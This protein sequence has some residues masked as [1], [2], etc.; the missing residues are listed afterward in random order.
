MSAPDNAQIDAV[1][2]HRL[3]GLLDIPD[4]RRDHFAWELRNSVRC[5]RCYAAKPQTKVDHRRRGRPTLD[6]QETDRFASFLRDL[7]QMACDLG[8]G[9]RGVFNRKKRR[10]KLVDLLNALRPIMPP[11]V[12][13]ETIDD[14]R[15]ALIER[16]VTEARRGQPCSAWRADIIAVHMSGEIWRAMGEQEPTCPDCGEPMHWRM[17]FPIRWHL[18]APHCP[19]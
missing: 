16:V 6:Q 17:R 5:E 3:A 8:G 4:D 15:L 18:R 7:L 14:A 19:H 11:G 10:G 13:P 9:G 2:W 1:D 12:I